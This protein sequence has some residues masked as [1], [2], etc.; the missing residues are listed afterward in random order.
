[1]LRGSSGV[2][3]RPGCLMNWAF[4]AGPRD[5]V[6]SGPRLVSDG[7]N[8]EARGPAG[9]PD[10][11]RARGDTGSGRSIPS[12]P[13]VR[14][15]VQKYTASQTHGELGASGLP[16]RSCA[17]HHSIGHISSN[18]SNVPTRHRELLGGRARSLTSCTAPASSK[19]PTPKRRRRRERH[20]RPTARKRRS[21]MCSSA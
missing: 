4:W 9:N 15:L 18:V 2:G 16:G 20:T 7:R 6:V 13:T 21:Q 19:H 10:R 11:G 8:Q 12:E 17:P 5:R 3:G 14:P 1:M